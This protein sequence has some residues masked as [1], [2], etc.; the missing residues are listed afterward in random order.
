MKNIGKKCVLFLHIY[1]EKVE[2]VTTMIDSQK[3]DFRT[4]LLDAQSVSTILNS[5]KNICPTNL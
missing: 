4:G 5:K 1:S 3:V 2:K